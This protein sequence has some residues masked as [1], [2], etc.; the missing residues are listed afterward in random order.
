MEKIRGECRAETVH[1]ISC[2][3]TH[4]PRVTRCAAAELE[5]TMSMS[6]GHNLTN[7]QSSQKSLRHFQNSVCLHDCSLINGVGFG[8][9]GSK[10][11][12]AVGMCGKTCLEIIIIE[13]YRLATTQNTL[14]TTKNNPATT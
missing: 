3:F 13:Y 5:V 7:T 6:G 4:V 9:M 12:R 10:I 8:Q 2:H 14:L 11:E 1:K